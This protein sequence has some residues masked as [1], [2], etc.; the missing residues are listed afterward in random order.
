MQISREKYLSLQIPDTG[1][2]SFAEGH[3]PM[4]QLPDALQRHAQPSQQ[5]DLQERFLILGGVGA[6]AVFTTIKM[7]FGFF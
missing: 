5:L 2:Q 7:Y 3:T 6:V 4:L 1:V